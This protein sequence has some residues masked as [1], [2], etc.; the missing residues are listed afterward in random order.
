[1]RNFLFLF[2]VIF[3]M[4]GAQAMAAEEP[5][6]DVIKKES[7]FEIREY[8]PYAI[9]A[10]NVEATKDEAGNAAFRPLF[11]YI[12]GENSGNQEYAMTVPVGQVSEK[13]AGQKFDMT[14]PVG[15][16]QNKNGSHKVYFVLPKNISAEIAPKPNDPNLYLEQIPAKRMAVITYSGRSN[17]EGFEKHSEELLAWV[18][19]NNLT[20]K[21]EPIF[22]TYNGPWTPWFARRNEVLIALKNEE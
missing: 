5:K 2:S 4:N 21:G 1:M 11:R 12:S 10:I 9:V 16:S 14:V 15:Q 6:F 7:S 8:E 19:Q 18:N 17:I 13:A 22:A 20:P 3:F